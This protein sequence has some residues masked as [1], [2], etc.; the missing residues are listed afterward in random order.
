MF[1]WHALSY[2]LDRHRKLEA[3]LSHTDK[4]LFVWHMLWHMRSNIQQFK[5]RLHFCPMLKVFKMECCIFNDV[6][7]LDISFTDKNKPPQHGGINYWNAM[8]FQLPFWMTSHH[9]GY[10][11]TLIT[12][13]TGIVSRL[14]Q[15]W[16]W[17]G[18]ILGELGQYH[19]CWCPGSSHWHVS[20]SHDY[21]YVRLRYLCQMISMDHTLCKNHINFLQNN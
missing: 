5:P 11:K 21:D 2:W 19:G 12:R 20:N 18:N 4:T 9:K 10:M 15:S 6:V 7:L 8:R 1:P 17:N 16:C 14:Y 13:A 3:Y